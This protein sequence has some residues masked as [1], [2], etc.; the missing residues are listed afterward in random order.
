MVVY[1]PFRTTQLR[2]FYSELKFEFKN[3]PQQL[4][5]HYVLATAVDMAEKGNLLRRWVHIELE[6]GVSR[7]ALKS[8][9]GM[10]LWAIMYILRSC[11]T[12]ECGV[13]EV[14]RTYLPPE[15]ACCCPKQIAWF[16]PEDQVLHYCDCT[17][18]VLHVNM[19]VV[20]KR[21]IYEECELPTVYFDRFYST[22]LMGARA[23]IMLIS[24][25]E[26]TNLRL[27]GELLKE[28]ERM[29]LQDA[30]RVSQRQQR[31]AVKMQFGK[32]M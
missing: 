28:Y 10:T 5:A 29:L 30:L 17:C 13:S 4:F 16:S 21:G 18:G 22:L 7:Y 9:D 26:W 11:G 15:S 1:E 2:E 19:A 6:P 14:T 23:R 3:L 25:R 12:L 32:V 31:G 24:G 20:P 27:G 8:P